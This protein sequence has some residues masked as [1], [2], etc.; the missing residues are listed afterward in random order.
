MESLIRTQG[1]LLLAVLGLSLAAPVLAAS[2][3]IKPGL[4]EMQMESSQGGPSAADMA[5]MQQAMK[6][7]QAQLAQM[8]PEQRR[9]LEER[10]GSM[11]ETFSD[12]G[13]RTCIT[14]EDLKQE[15]IPLQDEKNCKTDITTRTATR[16]A[17]KTVCTQPAITSE[18]EAIFDSPTSYVV[19]AKGTITQQGQ[20]KP[21]AMSMKWKYVSSD[22]GKVKPASE[23]R[24]N[25]NKK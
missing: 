10:M 1:R 3:N 16:W 6:Q 19:N 17:A 7:M 21:Y 11:S 24:S 20:T 18:A 13:I 15:R 25:L 5:K 4:W 8:P 9:M 12:K 22:C 23:I 14:A 2:P